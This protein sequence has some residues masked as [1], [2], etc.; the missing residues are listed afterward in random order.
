MLFLPDESL[1]PGNGALAL[2]RS[3][4]SQIDLLLCDVILPELSGPELSRCLASMR[5]RVPIL[6]MSGYPGP[7]MIER[8]LIQRETPYIEKPFTPE[9]LASAV[10]RLLYRVG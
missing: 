9:S 8:G 3:A 1:E 7:E 5:R 6:Y 2:L 10:R 4:N